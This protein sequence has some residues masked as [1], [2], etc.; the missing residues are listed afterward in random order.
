MT[1]VAVLA[2]T[3]LN[4][5]LVGAGPSTN[6]SFANSGLMVTL[7]P[8]E[9]GSNHPL[10]G[11]EALG[12][13]VGPDLGGDEDREGQGEGVHRHAVGRHVEGGVDHVVDEG[14]GRR[15]V[16][17]VLGD[18][19]AIEPTDRARSVLL[20]AH[21]MGDDTENEA[22]LERM[23]AAVVGDPSDPDTTVGPLARDDLR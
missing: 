18:G 23:R 3:D 6:N 2:S 21:G 9:F 22:V 7:N 13:H 10:A 15:G 8:D 1:V 17:A 19:Q 20:V 4:G 12:P 11:V 14:P 5:H 16:L